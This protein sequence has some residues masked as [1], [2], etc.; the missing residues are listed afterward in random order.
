VPFDDGA[1]FGANGRPIDI[2]RERRLS[3]PFSHVEGNSD[4]VNTRLQH[5]IN[6]Q[7]TARVN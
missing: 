2:P 1:I 4:F 7:W 5:A 6:A 3:E